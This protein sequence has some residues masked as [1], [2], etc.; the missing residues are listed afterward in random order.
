MPKDQSLA[1]RMDQR[2]RLAL[3]VY[4]GFKTLEAT[5]PLSVLG[6]ASRHL[7]DA[8]Y[9]G[10]YDITIAAPHVGHIPS[11]TAMSLE[12]TQDLEGFNAPDTVLIAGA[13]QIEEVLCAQQALVAWCR[14]NGP[15]FKPAALHSVRH[16]SF[17]PRPVF[18][19]GSAPPPIGIMLTDCEDVSRESMWM[20]TRSLCRPAASGP[21]PG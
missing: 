20:P 3:I 19:M 13:A 21:L 6:Y 16:P 5:G 18:W 17:W 7:A 4:P 2:R 11:D 10:G 8:G 1:C 12:A 9:A 14:A 15:R